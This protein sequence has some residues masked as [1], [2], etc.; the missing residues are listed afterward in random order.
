M[1]DLLQLKSTNHEVVSTL[2]FCMYKGFVC[3]QYI[4]N[5]ISTS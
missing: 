4:H 3:G 2:L 5:S 1:F